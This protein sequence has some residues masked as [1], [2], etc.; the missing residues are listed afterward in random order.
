M[1][2]M[3]EFITK[4]KREK[5]IDLIVNQCI[6]HGYSLY[7]IHIAITIMDKYIF[8]QYIKRNNFTKI[9]M[10]CLILASK[11]EET[12]FLD[13]EIA[14]KITGSNF[15]ES[16][17]LEEEILKA[18]NFNLY[19][20]TIIDNFYIDDFKTKDNYYFACYV[21]SIAL[22]D[23]N[24]VYLNPTILGPKIIK[25]CEIIT[26]E[27]NS[28]NDWI[29][30]E[31][32]F[33][34]LYYYWRYTFDTNNSIKKFFNIE[35]YNNVGAIMYPS[36]TIQVKDTN[37]I[38]EC[39]SK[40]NDSYEG[41]TFHGIPKKIKLDKDNPL[42]IQITAYTTNM[43]ELAITQK[44]L[45]Q[46]GSATVNHIKINNR[47]IAYKKFSL[48]YEGCGVYYN[49]LREINALIKLDHPNII[50]L[51]GYYLNTLKKN[52]GIGLELMDN[53]LYDKIMTHQVSYSTKKKYILQLLAGLKYMHDNKIMHR[54]LSIKNILVRQ[55]ELKIS[56]LGSSRLFRDDKHPM[57]FSNE[58]CALSFRPI[59]IILDKNPYDSKIDIWSCA[60]VIAFILLERL[61]F[62]GGS[63]ANLLS[64]IFSTLGYQK[65]DDNIEQWPGYK[66]IYSRWVSIS[67][68][69]GIRKL[70]KNYPKE[71]DVI[72]KMLRYSPDKRININESHTLFSE[73]YSGNDNNF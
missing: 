57:S 59:E 32:L 39:V 44:H 8:N 64:D 46:G 30:K 15:D 27:F 19:F 52:I 18:L 29:E 17:E 58:F 3:E 36:M 5:L 14:S 50:R 31:P 16:S 67:D 22:L 24:F 35:K 11:I 47:D 6:D 69:T 13:I 38:L 43:M 61:L 33:A 45:G 49:V 1:T 48:Y 4:E 23:F 40:N 10:I 55:D 37:F 68:R 20:G 41:N 62:N 72:Y 9:A 28:L 71:V 73:I 12:N 51:D 56:D 60:C 7:T 21:A 66:I 2:E 63:I 26:H 65:D 53:T 25:F 34:C 54:D 70:D 42:N